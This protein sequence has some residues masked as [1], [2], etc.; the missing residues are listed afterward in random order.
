[1]VLDWCT[2]SEADV[3]S[4]VSQSTVL[5]PLLLLTFIND[6]P[7]FL[8]RQIKNQRDADLLQQSLKAL[9]DWEKILQMSSHPSKCTV[10]RIPPQRKQLIQTAY[11]L[12]GHTLEVEEPS[13]YLG[14]T[15]S[16][17]LTWENISTKMLERGTRCLVS[18]GG[19]SGTAP[20]Q[21]RRQHTQYGPP[22]Y[23]IRI[24]SFGPCQPEAYP[25]A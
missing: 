4:G 22:G 24:H 23:G 10:I 16:E 11:T 21:S 18:P 17:D 6:L 15:I 12:H 8:F 19:I 2:S 3:L 20:S 14:I 9:E 5:G 13:K 25:A 7:E 1:M